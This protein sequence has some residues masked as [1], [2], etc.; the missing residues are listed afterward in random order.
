MSNLRIA[1][2]INDAAF[3]VSHRLPIA[4]EVL[5]QGGKV[6]IITG[7]NI[8]TKIENEAIK[9][10]KE[11]KIKHYR[12]LFSQ[13]FRNPI[14]EIIGLYQSIIFLRKFNP[15]TI[16]SATAKGNLIASIAS[17]FVNINKLILSVSGVGTLI[18]GKNNLKRNIYFFLYR[19]LI[20]VSLKRINYN[21]IFQNKDDCKNYKSFLNFKNEQSFIIAGSGVDTSSLKPV[22]KN[23]N[24]R[25]ILLPARLLYEKGIEEFVKASKLLKQKNVKGIF[26]LCGDSNSINPSKI[27]LDIIEK[28]VDE[29]LIIYR[30]YYSDIQ[31]MYQDI[32]IVCLPSWREGFPKVLM[33][34][35]S[36]GLPV[37]TTDV[38]GCRDAV[39]KNVTGILVP[40][41]DEIKL[42]NAISKLFEDVNLRKK[43]GKANRELAIE[44]FD[45]VQIVNKVIKLYY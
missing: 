37:I 44:K 38:P 7:Q 35:A 42:A 33:E 1:Y 11:L 43:M 13:S 23:K 29:G 22:I 8:S 17:N 40:A 5:K 16:H 10:L 25:N 32:D 28:W 27:K 12:C 26:Y 21:I 24:T 3:F 41:K 6:C 39:I 31:K 20:K 14:K 15:S 30:G 18:I 34:A 45:L 9:K 4:I 2:I 36:F 19:F